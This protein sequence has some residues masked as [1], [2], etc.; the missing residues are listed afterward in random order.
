MTDSALGF[1]SH[2]DLA[3]LW[4]AVPGKP[5]LSVGVG[6]IPIHVVELKCLWEAPNITGPLSNAVLQCL[7]RSEL[8]F[9]ELQKRMSLPK[10]WLE[11]ILSSLART[12]L[13]TDLNAD[14]RFA[15]EQIIRANP[16]V[17][18]STFYKRHLFHFFEWSGANHPLYI[19]IPPHVGVA[20]QQWTLSKTISMAYLEELTQLP[21][22]QKTALKFPPHIKQLALPNLQQLDSL[23]IHQMQW[24]AVLC[25]TT[26]DQFQLF[27]LNPQD[28]TLGEQSP[29]LQKPL[30]EPAAEKIIQ[31][32]PQPDRNAWVGA[33]ES[34]R[35]ALTLPP[36]ALGDYQELATG[37]QINIK[38]PASVVDRLHQQHQPTTLWLT[39]GSGRFRRAAQAKLTGS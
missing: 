10:P 3:T 12:G 25:L 34:V 39:A 15:A 33:W 1:P 36:A 9:N 28:W 16:G 13:I 37:P 24:L 23:V 8:T 35:R 29:F 14:R 21:L 17:S 6:W 26:P 2:Q 11:A 20:M 18:A 27:S 7:S 31:L 4:E 30:S 38:L 22:E 19:N 32:I 5:Y